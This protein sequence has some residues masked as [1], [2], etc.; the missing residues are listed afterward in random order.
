MKETL[1]IKYS[2]NRN[3]QYSICTSIFKDGNREWVEKRPVTVEAR[4]HVNKMLLSGK[5]LMEIYANT[6][7]LMCPCEKSGES[8]KFDFIQ[9]VSVLTGFEKVTEENDT[10]KIALFCQKYI[11]LITSGRQMNFFKTDEFV[12]CFG[13]FAFPNGT[14]SMEYTNLD[15]LMENVIVQSENQYVTID[16]EWC[17]DF[18]IPVGF[19]SYRALYYA[20]ESIGRRSFLMEEIFPLLGITRKDIDIYQKMEQR[21]QY[22]VFSHSYPLEQNSY[23][24][25]KKVVDIRC[26]DELLEETKRS[27]QEMEQTLQG[28]YYS[29][30]WKAVLLLRK[31][32]SRVIPFNSR[33]RLALKLGFKFVR[34]PIR[35]LK[36]VTP[37]R[38]KGLIE[39]I[40]TN[41]ADEINWKLNECVSGQYLKADSFDLFP[42]RQDAPFGSYEP[43]SFLA[44]FA[45]LV[46]I[47]IP[48]YNQFHYTYNCLKAIREHSGNIPYEVIIADDG[49]SD[50]TSRLSEIVT[51]L[52]IIVNQKNLRFL[53]NCNN[54]AKQARG[55]YILFLN[56][57]TQVQN[58]WLSS[59]V[60]LIESN[61]SIGMVGSKLV[62]PDGRLQEAGG[63]V[64][65]DGSAWN[66]GRGQDMT[67][68]E[69]C[70]VKESDY[71]SG[72]AIMIR[73]GLW[74]EIGGFDERFAPAYCEDTDLAFS[75]RK[76][77]Y[78]VL[79]Q[80]ESIVVHFEGVSNG[81]D[82]NEGQKSYQ[83]QNQRKFYEKWEG[84]LQAEHFPNAVDPFLARDR[85][86]GRKTLL[87][88]DHYVPTFDRDAGSKTVYQYLKLFVKHGYN[89]KFIGDN[90]AVMQPYTSMLQQMGIEVLNGS[91]YAKNW[92]S[93]LKE[94]G[95]HI[96]YV[97]L[98]R[99]HI[100]VKY[101]DSVRKYTSAK[102]VYYGHDFHY[103]RTMREYE[104]TKKGSLLK[105]AEEWKRKEFELIKKADLS[106]YPSQIEVDEIHRI[107]S[108]LNVKA[109]P[110][111]IYETERREHIPFMKSR[112]ILFVG[113]YV[114]TP[115]VDAALW[116]VNEILPMVWGSLPNMKLH[117]IGSNAPVEIVKLQSENVIF[118]GKISQEK[119]EELYR[120]CRIAVMPLRYGAGI[121]GKVIEAMENGCPVLTTMVGAE[122]LPHVEDSVCIADT[123]DKFAEELVHLYQNTDKLERLS[124][125]GHEYVLQNFSSESAI[126]NIGPDFG[127]QE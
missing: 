95:K 103:L 111:Y 74:Q 105:E 124:N 69:Y 101:I 75:V 16:Y 7:I 20:F 63:I 83:V 27:C 125:K 65:K 35:Y 118:E 121:K 70:Y 81:T 82:L 6:N 9:G 28:I 59:L 115:N 14:M 109:I 49:S 31:I 34:H 84:V 98:N 4:D 57:D 54:A 19:V 67:R 13:D 40:S 41:N 43:I 123:A 21:F 90:F 122:G 47:I 1:L 88:V 73:A 8:V 97:W 17:F 85:S 60:Q 26:L 51:G 42:C 38:V 87:M 32:A 117:L 102:I 36:K 39:R 94:N 77:G 104:L 18:P 96:D 89:V 79:F 15:F 64:W 52:N 110:A 2:N 44:V 78:K 11:S 93:W 108:H 12:S 30:S 86:K 127:M 112:D 99:P 120:S 48:V 10:S 92:K 71:I 80:P 119:L 113:G 23:K 37:S 55:Q 100:S 126:A 114:H 3:I 66:Y 25:R 106:Y 91:Y 56:N 33:R 5:K 24:L 68:P 62:Y 72:A 46:S 45:P 107:D 53:R 58:G 61:D 29:H 50:F 76:A 22:L 116:L